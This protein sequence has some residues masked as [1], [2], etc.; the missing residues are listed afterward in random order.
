VQNRP[1]WLR[2]GLIDA[3]NRASASVTE[4]SRP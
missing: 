2:D 1:V 3:K 4:I